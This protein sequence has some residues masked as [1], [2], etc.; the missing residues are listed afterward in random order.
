MKL[1]NVLAMVVLI[2]ATATAQAA[3]SFAR[4]TSPAQGV[5]ASISSPAKS[6]PHATPVPSQQIASQ[7]ARSNQVLKKKQLKKNAS[8]K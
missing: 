2:S 4:N 8:K 6:M 5:R 1:I 7:R 3:N